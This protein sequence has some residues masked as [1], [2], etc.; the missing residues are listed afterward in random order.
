M[1]LRTS[2]QVKP[3]TS[4]LICLTMD[5]KW[6]T[7]GYAA[8]ELVYGRVCGSDA[9]HK[10]V[11]QDFKQHASSSLSEW[12]VGSLTPGHSPC[13]ICR[14]S[15]RLLQQ[16]ELAQCAADDLLQAQQAHVPFLGGHA[17]S[18]AVRTVLQTPGR[19]LCKA[20]REATELVAKPPHICCNAESHLCIAADEAPAWVEAGSLTVV[21]GL[22][23]SHLV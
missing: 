8:A 16:G 4:C 11:L 9:I 22:L 17:G 2:L 12:C 7:D 10:R 1:M 20:A 15:C 21:L 14:C 3:C 23:S 18:V 5:Q 13:V 19:H 6:K